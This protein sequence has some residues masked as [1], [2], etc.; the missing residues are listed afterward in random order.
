ML[1]DAGSD[2]PF[3][4]APAVRQHHAPQRCRLLAFARLAL[5]LFLAVLRVLRPNVVGAL[6][7]QG[8]GDHGGGC[9]GGTGAG[10]GC[11]EEGNAL[12]C[13]S[14]RNLRWRVKMF[15]PFT[16][17][18]LGRSCVRGRP[19]QR[20]QKDA[21]R[22]GP[23]G[24]RPARQAGIRLWQWLQPQRL[25]HLR[26]SKKRR[27]LWYVSTRAARTST[28]IFS[29]NGRMLAARIATR[30]GGVPLS[31]P[32]ARSAR[33]PGGRKASPPSPPPWWSTN[34]GTKN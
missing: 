1:V 24:A 22:M 34:G 15:G 3:Q 29:R 26:A 13:V 6:G 2:S 27:D 9:G 32:S 25:I 5:R 20:Q 28:G 12:S 30:G 23:L 33:P 31:H 19:L 10:A 7:T 21:A 18:L 8:G 17:L 4:H 11:A 14:L 16:F